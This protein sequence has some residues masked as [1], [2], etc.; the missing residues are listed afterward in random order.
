MRLGLRALP[1]RI[2]RFATEAAGNVSLVVG[3]SAPVLLGFAGV[4]VDYSTWTRQA[5][6]L[7]KAADT[8]ALAAA[9][10]LRVAEPDR[11]RIQAVAEAV[12]K[13]L[14]KL[15]T[16]D[17]P[18]TVKAEPVAEPGGKKDDDPERASAVKVTLWQ[19]KA[20]IMS[21][22]VTP[23][24][25]D[26]EVSATANLV[27][28]TKIC[29]IGLDEKAA[30]TVRLADSARISAGG[31]S[32]YVNST[33]PAAVRSE[34]QARVTSLLI[35]TAGGYKGASSNFAPKAPTTDCPRTKD[36]LAGRPTPPVGGCKHNDLVLG[37]GLHL[38]LNPGT[39][40]GGLT[41]QPGAIVT[42][43]PGV[44]VIK[45]GPLHVGPPVLS[46]SVA[47]L[48]SVSLL[49][50]TLKGTN[51]AFYFTGTVKPEKDGSVVPMRF[52]KESVVEMTAPKTGEMAGLL[53]RE[54]PAAPAER[55][56]E[57]VSDSARRLVGTIYLPRGVFSVSANQ[58]V[59]DKSEYTAIITKRMELFQ[60]PNLVLNT[61]YFDTDVPVPEGVGPN[62]GRTR[63]T[64]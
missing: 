25:T 16:G 41:L 30:D 47:G 39:Y 59:A 11:K 36:P 28:G 31:C 5:T 23:E 21:R 38:P 52:M 17:E 42:L 63:L 57:V 44:Y 24:L 62:S 49:P 13:G 60:A 2:A 55:R 12:V 54:D 61:R 37:A 35:C 20:A 10:E 34:D 22:I 18:V 46:V 32:V 14:V 1:A 40:C 27:G 9:N 64:R 3:L 45:D 29:V 4:A 33:S 7:Q 19:R 53:L 50:A 56:F 26:L 15:G 58:L 6:I 43:N 8:A 51:V 48:V